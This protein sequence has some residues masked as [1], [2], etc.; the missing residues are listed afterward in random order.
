[1]NLFPPKSV[2]H[3]AFTLIELL[4]VITIIAV[5][6][7]L[8]LPVANSV[9][10]NA[11]KTQAKNTELQIITAVKSFQ[12]DYGVYPLPADAPANTDVCFGAQNPTTA[13]LFYSLRAIN[14]ANTVNLNP[15]GVV[16]I[17]LPKAK[18]Q[19]AGLSKSG[20]GSN[21]MLYDPWGTIFLIGVEGDYDGTVKNPYSKNAGPVPLQTGV[22][23]YSWGPDQ[24]TTS[25]FYGGGDKNDQT[26]AD[27]II[28]W[29]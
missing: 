4:V 8:L 27:D 18:I 22:I 12:T 3:R 9:M 13:E 5:L 19:T 11:R 15:R 2:S 24:L 6:A 26:S 28:S 29:Q 7:G 17:E 1:M 16:Y 25:N 10:T 14:Q 23:V 21:G 20:L